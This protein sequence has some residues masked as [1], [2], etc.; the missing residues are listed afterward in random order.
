MS[1]DALLDPPRAARPM[2]RRRP[3]LVAFTFGY[4]FVAGLLIA[5]PIAALFNSVVRDEP[6]GDAVLFDPGGLMFVESIRL[7]S[8][9]AP[10]AASGSGAMAL[11]ATF[12]GLL[13]FAALVTGLGREGRL[14]R[15]FLAARAVRSIGTLALLWGGGLVAQAI[16]GGLLG[17]LLGKL[18]GA[19]HLGT[20]GE[21]IGRVVLVAVVLLAVLAV[22]VLRDL[23]AVSAVNDGTR[24]YTSVQR[25]LRVMGGAGGRV[26]L[27]Y[28]WRGL[29]GL[30]AVLGAGAAVMSLDGAPIALPFLLHQLAIAALVFAHASW[31]A[32]AIGLLHAAAP[33]ELPRPAAAPAPDLAATPEPGPPKA[34]DA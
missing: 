34:G 14:S 20:P 33:V 3:G 17:V 27:A 10:G 12:L 11:V 26:A 13:P 22:G 6:R 9:G 1:D 4:R 5:S 8:N 18:A 21:D 15:A 29:L 32:A 19:L 31:L 7:T 16:L 30:A 2:A 28:A 23:A 25:A 24:L